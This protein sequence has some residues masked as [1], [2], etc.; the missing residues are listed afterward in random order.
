[1]VRVCAALGVAAI[2]VGAAVAAPLPRI[3]VDTRAEAE[4]QL[5]AAIEDEQ[6]V[7][8]LIRKS[9]PRIE[10]ARQRIDSS[11]A[12]LNGVVDYLSAVPG[13]AAAESAAMSARGFDYGAYLLISAP[14]GPSDLGK[15]RAIELLER[16]I[17]S[18]R[19][20]LRVLPDERPASSGQCADG[21]DNDGDGIVD[22]M[23]EPGCSSARDVRERSP[24]GCDVRPGVAAGRLTLQ[25]SCSGAFSEVELTLLD[26]LQ[27]NGR[28]DVKHAPS[29]SPPTVTKIR[30]RTKNGAQN[31]GRLVDLR[32]ATTAREPGQ[33]VQLR[34]FDVRKRQ[35]AR[36]VV[37]AR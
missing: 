30:C 33:R 7:I 5:R 37:P 24:F 19:G 32:L 10:T 35:I 6:R 12:R 17:L 4:A 34:F 36:F 11:T 14:G 31:P 21:K 16:A 26:G 15:R 9:P 1:V 28:F 3:P 8:E 23:L 13:A 25:G 18:K 20:A 29:C 22:W 27:L 2:V